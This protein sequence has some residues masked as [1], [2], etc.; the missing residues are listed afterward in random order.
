MSKTAYHQIDET[1]CY[2]RPVIIW[3]KGA[4]L[5]FCQPASGLPRETDLVRPARLVRFVP[6]E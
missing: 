6:R 2:A 1:S 5:T 4:G 3:V